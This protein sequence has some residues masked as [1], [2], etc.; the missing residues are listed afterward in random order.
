MT[1]APALDS[2][3]SQ[4]HCAF[5]EVTE[6][7]ETL[8]K[9]NDA[10][11][12]PEGRPYREIRILH[13]LVL[14]DPLEDPPGFTRVLSERG[15]RTENLDPSDP[16]FKLYRGRRVLSPPPTRE[17]LI[18]SSG[19]PPD[20]VRFIGIGDEIENKNGILE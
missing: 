8:S 20:D 6:G 2:L 14:D 16:L 17:R 19:R 3:D 10:Y 12:S 15:L 7:F 18:D 5:G 9:L 1:L 4:R 11:C 13:T